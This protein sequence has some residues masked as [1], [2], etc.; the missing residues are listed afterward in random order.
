MLANAVIIDAPERITVQDVAVDSPKDGDVVVRVRHS[1]I[2]T[3]TEKL[4]WSGQMPPFPGMG[5]PLIPGYEAT[6]EIVETR[7]NSGLSIGTQVFVPGASCYGDIRGLF[8]G[9]TD[10]LTTGADRVIAI[11][12]HMGASG[13]ILALAATA[14]H[15]M[16][17]ID[18]SLPELIVGHGVVGRLLARLTIAA[19]GKSPMVWEVDETRRAGAMGYQVLE[20]QDDPRKDYACI[21]DATGD[22]GILDQLIARLAPG[23]ELVLAGFY[24]APLTFAFPPAFMREARLRV[25]AEW[26]RDDL[27][28]TRDLI[29]QGA[30]SLEGLI[31]HHMP[32]A[33]AP[34]AYRTAFSDPACLKMILDWE[35]SA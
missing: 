22:S 33:E 23:G 15:A 14:R 6:G 29:D 10:L 18:K 4:F 11:D 24:P 5:Y 28:A 34:S 25:A 17:G 27:V 13:A 8:G 26:T 9:A 31:T 16:A 12:R 35:A 30:L 19:G 2:S 3:G 20:P 1:G 32:A 21:Y 7:G